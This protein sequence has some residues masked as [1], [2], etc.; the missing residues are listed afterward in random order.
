M[1]ERP[2]IAVIGAGIAGLAAARRLGEAGAYVTLLDKARGLGGRLATRRAEGFAFDHGAQFFTLREP[3]FRQL[4]EAA[5]QA[6]AAAPWSRSWGRWRDGELGREAGE[7]VRWVGTPGMSSFCRHLGEGQDL[8]TERSVQ[9]L[10]RHGDGWGIVTQRGPLGQHFDAV[11]VAVPAPQARA[12]VEGACGFAE[13][14]GKASY[15]PCWA[16]MAGFAERLAVESDAI[17]F[18]DAVLA[19]AARD[20]SKPGRAA[21]AESWVLHAT[22]AWSRAELE[23]RPEEVAQLLMDRF[24]ELL[25]LSGEPS[26][27][28]S[29]LLGHRWRFARVEQALGAPCLWDAEAGIGACGD[30]CLGPRVEE[31]W[32]SGDA[33]GAAMA[34]SLCR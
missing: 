11:A 34:E 14:L 6:E 19:W 4:V 22:P 31:A 1:P 24:R 25:G 27:E 32:R 26:G 8:V 9:E 7:R 2:S 18:E 20:G 33:L 29:L 28:P 17:E 10:V 21:E 12:L 15:A 30:W 23:R 16:A 5:E 13:R 3:A